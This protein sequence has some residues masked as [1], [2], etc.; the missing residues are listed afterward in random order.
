M[1]RRQWRKQQRR[2]RGAADTKP[3]STPVV[4]PKITA[5]EAA[6]LREQVDK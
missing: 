5:E 4:A 3:K 2:A 6:R 1:S